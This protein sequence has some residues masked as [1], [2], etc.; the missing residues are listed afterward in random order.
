LYPNAE[1]TRLSKNGSY[2][3]RANHSSFSHSFLSS[4]FFFPETRIPVFA[5]RE[6][7]ENFYKPKKDFQPWTYI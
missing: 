6:D 1:K 4:S 3:S 7:Q 5:G 2:G